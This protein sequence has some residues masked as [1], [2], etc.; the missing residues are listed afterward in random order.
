MSLPGLCSQAGS[1]LCSAGLSLSKCPGPLCPSPGDPTVGS[2]WV[3]GLTAPS[4]SSPLT[5]ARGS[6]AAFPGRGWSWGTSNCLAEELPPHQP[7]TTCS[8]GHGILGRR[9][10]TR[11][12]TWTGGLYPLSTLLSLEGRDGWGN[13]V[14]FFFFNLI[15]IFII[16]FGCGRS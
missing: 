6:P 13:C 7:P 11:I 1:V 2:S 14:P 8:V 5:L 16:L 9:M 10:G 4:L 15:F 3:P 12:S